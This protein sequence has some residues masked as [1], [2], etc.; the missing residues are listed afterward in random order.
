MFPA[1]VCVVACVLVVKVWTVWDFV[2]SGEPAD[3]G[4][5]VV[6][7]EVIEGGDIDSE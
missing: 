1:I 5:A 3:E 4:G 6:S 2:L 7:S